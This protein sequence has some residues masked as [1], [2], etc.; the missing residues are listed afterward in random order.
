MTEQ[1]FQD[2]E[3]EIVNI[4]MSLILTKNKYAVDIKVKNTGN[5]TSKFILKF[6][7]P[8][9]KC[10]ISEKPEFNLNV[11]QIKDL[12][13]KVQP[14]KSGLQILS[15]K[16]FGLIKKRIKSQIE[17]P[18]PNY[19]PPPQVTPGLGGTEMGNIQQ[20][21]P[22]NV[23]KTIIKE[24]INEKIE[25]NLISIKNIYFNVIDSSSAPKEISHFINIG[26]DANPIG[27]NI[28]SHLATIFF[29]NP[30][31]I[32]T[33]DGQNLQFIRD[34]FFNL[35]RNR[36]EPFYYL[37]YPIDQEYSQEDTLVVKN[38]FNFF[39]KNQLPKDITE[40]NLFNLNFIPSITN[41]PTII[42]GKDSD[43]NYSKILQKLNNELKTQIEIVV[44]N[45]IFSHG[46]LYEDLKKIT[47][48]MRVNLVNILLTTNLI[49]NKNLFI[50]L[51]NIFQ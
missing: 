45:D 31:L 20:P 41:K 32:N 36:K 14:L 23:P 17:V 46:R 24:V 6:Q 25:E 39:I 5:I 47:Q 9:L 35:K 21:Q 7:Y 8:N 18:N 44:D 51:I 27:E 4:P 16:V 43:D 37:T 13:I 49:K 38:A 34:I 29:Y 2:C 1:I 3:I 48:N 50:K 26:G 11:D 28:R 10:E 40:L 30:E 42:I 15:I 19:H 33:E 12:S 22:Y